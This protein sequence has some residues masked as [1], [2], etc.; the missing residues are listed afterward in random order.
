MTA[1]ARIR[2]GLTN[3]L[4]CGECSAD[5]FEQEDGGTPGGIQ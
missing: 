2:G 1:S 4:F 3:L 5:V